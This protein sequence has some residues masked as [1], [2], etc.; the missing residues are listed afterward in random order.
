MGRAIRAER[1]RQRL[2]GR[3]LADRAGDGDDLRRRARA[4]RSREIAQRRQHVVD[5]DEPRV[6]AE[7]GAQAIDP[8]AC[9]HREAAAGLERGG[10]KSWP[11][12]TSPLMAK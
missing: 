10:A 1:E 6:V 9:D 7:R 2:L 4:R 3:G 8:V 12:W 5:G 11:S